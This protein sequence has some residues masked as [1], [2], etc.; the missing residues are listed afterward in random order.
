MSLWAGVS[1]LILASPTVSS[2]L[3]VEPI[4]I[5]VHQII[6]NVFLEEVLIVQIISISISHKNQTLFMTW[7]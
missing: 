3:E 7:K 6:Q 2:R 1:V 5:Q 4:S